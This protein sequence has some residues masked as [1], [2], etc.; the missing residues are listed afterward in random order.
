[1]SH[2]TVRPISRAHAGSLA[3]LMQEEEAD[4]LAELRWDYSPVR[5]I[6]TSLLAM[7]MLPGFAAFDEAQRLCGYMYFLSCQSKGVLGAVYVSAPERHKDA[8][9]QLL[10]PAIDVLKGNQAIARI[11]AQMMP[12]RG[13]DLEAAFE[14]FHFA[15]FGRSYL[16]LHLQEYK[17]ERQH[18][19]SARIVPWDSRHIGRLAKVLL[20]SY[21]GEIDGSIC[22]DYCSAQAGES[23][24]RSIVENPGCGVFRPDASCV[25]ITE[26][27]R[28]TAFIMASQIS[29]GAAMIPQI[30]VHPDS[31]GLGLGNALMRTALSRLKASGAGTVSLTVT[32]ANSRA[33]EWYRRLGFV[34]RKRFCAFVWKRPS[35]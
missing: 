17:G 11:E 26:G 28:E 6:L 3:A 15:K 8:A 7:K 9:R 27:G 31:R 30:A 1:M 23:Y 5:Q 13:L 25:A 14:G 16:E 10:A 18:A 35:F 34:V 33:F 4:W 2:L 20:D 12:M 21:T 32:D 24:I 29:D 19:H 22:E